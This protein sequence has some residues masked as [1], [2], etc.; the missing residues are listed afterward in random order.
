M[1][2]E[3]RLRRAPPD[4]GDGARPRRLA[5]Y[6]G[7]RDRRW[8]K[9]QGQRA[10]GQRDWWTSTR[11]RRGLAVESEYSRLGPD[12]RAVEEEGNADLA[13]GP[14]VESHQRHVTPRSVPR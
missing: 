1:A 7:K 6:S 10:P 3:R 9:S 2:V 4:A 12:R 14:F 13:I 5:A 8:W 11:S